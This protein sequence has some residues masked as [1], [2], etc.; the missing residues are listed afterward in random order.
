MLRAGSAGSN[1]AA[2]HITVLGE[3][4][5]ALPPKYRRRLM[6]TC[7][8]AGASH[9]LIAHLHALASRPGHQLIYSVGWEL[10]TREKHAI[11]AVP[12]RAWQITV[13]HRGEVRERRADDACTHH[14][15]THRKCWIEQAQVTELTTLLRHGPTGD[16]LAGW[17]A[18]MRVFA[19]REGPHP[20]AQVTLFETADGWRYSLW[21][22]NLPERTPAGAANPPT[23]TPPTGCTHALRMPSAP[24]NTPASASSPP[25]GWPSTAPG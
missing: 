4:I 9:A 16:Q 10:G 21:V 7:D 14:R 8:G 22:T 25:T 20:G 15:C 19:R 5:A 13:D 11:S 2:D 12:E 18:S 3:A 17:P 6:V 24:A 23:S 1:T